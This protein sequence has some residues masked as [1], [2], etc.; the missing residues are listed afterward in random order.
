MEAARCNL[1]GTLAAS[2]FRQSGDRVIK[3]KDVMTMS[4]VTIG[5]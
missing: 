5:S 2:L 4:V 3:A 1:Q